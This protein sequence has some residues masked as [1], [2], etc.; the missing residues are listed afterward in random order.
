MPLH[1]L[2]WFRLASVQLLEW[3]LSTLEPRGF[4]ARGLAWH[5]N[6]HCAHSA[7][8]E[9]CTD[10]ITTHIRCSYNV[11]ENMCY[12]VSIIQCDGVQHPTDS[13][14]S[15]SFVVRNVGIGRHFFFNGFSVLQG[16]SDT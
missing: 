10:N 11:A 15:T 1:S 2:L 4:F 14:Y 13:E 12:R 9:A 3:I 5:R 6:R 7:R 8:R 16:A